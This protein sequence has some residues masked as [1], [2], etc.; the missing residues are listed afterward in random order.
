M[1]DRWEPPLARP[2]ASP[3]A[4]P[5]AR[6]GAGADEL[7]PGLRRREPV[8]ASPAAAEAEDEYTVPTHGMPQELAMIS[9][10]RTQNALLA[11][12]QPR[13]ASGADAITG[14]LLESDNA[15]GEDGGAL[16]LPG[17]KGAAA[18]EAF[19]Q[20]VRKNPLNLA[21]SVYQNV[22]TALAWGPLPHGQQTTHGRASMRAYLTQRTGSPTWGSPLRRRGIGSWTAPRSP[23]T[24][25]RRFSRWSAAR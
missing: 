2:P 14:L 17:A 3:I 11:R 24:T 21:R 20:E 8:G 12:L 9:M 5:A 23:W 10:L 16:R 25:R 22:Q 4:E 19:R 15:G 7:P 1:Y 13:A 6:R 18:R